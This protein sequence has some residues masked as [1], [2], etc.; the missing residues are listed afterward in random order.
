[1]I[2]GGKVG[3]TTQPLESVWLL[4]L[5][6]G[7]GSLWKRSDGCGLW[8]RRP[9]ASAASHQQTGDRRRAADQGRGD[10]DRRRPGGLPVRFC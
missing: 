9:G 3:F 2:I 1:M 8:R 4:D 6:C 10:G 7:S 5:G